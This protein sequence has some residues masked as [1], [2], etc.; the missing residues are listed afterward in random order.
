[1]KWKAIAMFLFIALIV[2]NCGQSKELT[3]ERS[4]TI[5]PSDL[6]S[7]HPGVSL[8]VGWMPYQ[9]HKLVQTGD[10][11]W[12]IVKNESDDNGG[13]SPIIMVTY[14]GIPD[15]MYLD[16][17][18]DNELLGK[19]IK[20]SAI[21]QQRISRPFATFFENAKC[22]TCHPKHIKIDFDS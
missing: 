22:E 2:M 12:K 11:E 3:L 8:T 10:H 4:R 1:M 16:M 5:N 19:L 17:N 15:T 18:I 13:M 14:P 9:S 20:H 7:I 21:T 6:S